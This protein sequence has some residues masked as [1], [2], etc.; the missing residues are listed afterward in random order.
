MFAPDSKPNTG[1]RSENGWPS[2]RRSIGALRPVT[3]PTAKGGASLSTMGI[4]TVD[5][6]TL[7]F[8]ARKAAESVAHGVFRWY[9]YPR[10]LLAGS[11]VAWIAL[12]AYSNLGR[13]YSLDL[14]VYRSAAAALRAG[15]NPYL[16]VF[17]R[18]HLPFTYPPFALLVFLPL[19]LGPDNLIEI[20]W[21]LIN[22]VCTVAI[23]YLLM[24]RSCQVKGRLAYYRSLLIAPVFCIALEPLRSDLDYGQINA[25]LLLAVLYDLFSMR[26][27]RRG[28]LT[29]L[30]IAVKLTPA[31]FIVYLIVSRDGR[32]VIRSAASFMVATALGFVVLPSQSLHYWS[33]YPTQPGRTGRVSSPVNQ[34]L[35]GALHRWPSLHFD[36]ALWLAAVVVTVI[37]GSCLARSLVRRQQSVAAAVALGLTGE[38]VSP[39][40]WTHHW[41]WIVAV[42]F[43]VVAKPRHQ[44]GSAIV[45]VLMVGLIVVA[46]LAP[47]TW[48]NNGWM[49]RLDAD[50][51]VGLGAALLVAWTVCELRRDGR[52]SNG[53]RQSVGRTMRIVGDLGRDSSG[54]RRSMHRLH[55]I[56]FPP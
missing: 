19:S 12:G 2:S 44:V 1:N 15:H 13:R 37:A 24:T 18:H 47:Y 41:I 3:T 10:L 8:R 42:P 26:P 39:V 31:I 35:Y 46:C 50:S 20:I 48:N 21:W 56:P 7:R 33:S 51:L 43:L 52:K 4:L 53:S 32:A 25:L 22:V 16:E 38:L 36:E 55:R 6:P 34:S 45:K 14:L 5:A 49:G 27:G 23:V 17:T 28:I 30:A 40:S 9:T 54:L 29:G 11:V